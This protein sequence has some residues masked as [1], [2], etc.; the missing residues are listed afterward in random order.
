ML[1]DKNK[2]GFL[3]SIA[4]LYILAFLFIT[5][6]TTQPDGLIKTVCNVASSALMITGTINLINQYLLRQALVDMILVKI[7]LK[8]DLE[9]TGIERIVS[10]LSELNCD[11]YFQKAQKSIDII[12]V[13]GLTWTNTHIH[14]IKEA[15]EEK[16]CKVQV[17]MYS[18]DA[19]FLPALAL[20]VDTP[21]SQFHEKIDEVDNVWKKIYCDLPVTKRKNLKLY[22]HEGRPSKSLYRIDNKIIMIPN[23]IS[24]GRSKIP[25]FIVKENQDPNCL[26]N[27][28]NYE[29]KEL[30]KTAVEVNLEQVNCI[31]IQEKISC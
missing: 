11:D 1:S 14:T 17:Y 23:T 12:H 3:F 27:L 19:I 31:E 21:L 24:K 9:R 30:H 4:V 6:A 5:I 7:G 29:I 22:Y 2:I 13:Y 28:F 15:I 18:R 26:Y 16:N 20:H 25:A 10:K 8:S